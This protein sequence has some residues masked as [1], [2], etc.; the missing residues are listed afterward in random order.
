M[1]EFSIKYRV[2]TFYKDTQWLLSV[3]GLN[4][5]LCYQNFELNKG[6]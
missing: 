5:D 2:K 3:I 6:N 1:A 4:K